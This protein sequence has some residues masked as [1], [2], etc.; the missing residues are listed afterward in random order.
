MVQWLGIDDEG[1]I[2]PTLRGEHVVNLLN[3]PRAEALDFDTGSSGAMRLFDSAD[4][5]DDLRNESQLLLLRRGTYRI[6]AACFDSPGI[7]MIVR[8]IA[9]ICA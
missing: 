2:E 4:R 9:R 7:A 5:G 3:H 6:R 8:E 1:S